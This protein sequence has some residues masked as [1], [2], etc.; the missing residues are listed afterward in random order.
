MFDKEYFYTKAT[1]TEKLCFNNIISALIDV[2]LSMVRNGA[3]PAKVPLRSSM[4]GYAE[5]VDEV[6]FYWV[7]PDNYKEYANGSGPDGASSKY[8]N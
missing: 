3:V 2:I 7:S 1:D 8:E 5:G 4:P 6:W